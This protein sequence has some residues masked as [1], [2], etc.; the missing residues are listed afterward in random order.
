M[1]PRTSCVPVLLLGGALLLGGCGKSPAEAAT[2]A[3]IR[4]STGKDVK[5]ERDGDQVTF[6]TEEGEM[7]ISGG[8]NLALPADFPAD[9]YLPP[10][11]QVKSLMNVAQ[12]SIV[13]LAAPGSLAELSGAADAA[14][15]GHGWKQT[16]AM[17]QDDFRMYSYEKSERAASLTLSPGEGGQVQLS[18][19]LRHGRQ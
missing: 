11:Y 19:Q 5:V 15:L 13:Q 8:E 1:I 10:G 7:T 6:Q 12:A 9:V 18:M 2:E 3:A 17:Q 4:A 14:M 16:M